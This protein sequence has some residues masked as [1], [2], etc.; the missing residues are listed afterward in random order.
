MRLNLLIVLTLGL[1]TLALADYMRCGNSLV[2]EETPPPE[3]LKKCGEPQRRES[4]T[5]DVFAV[6]AAGFRYKTGVQ[7]IERWYYRR[8]AGSLPMVVTIIDGKMK[9]ILRVE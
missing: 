3:L 8:D 4:A 2:N 6:N 7:Q 5:E 1:P 9:S